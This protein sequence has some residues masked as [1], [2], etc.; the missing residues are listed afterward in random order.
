MKQEA[1][2]KT[3]LTSDYETVARVANLEQLPLAGILYQLLDSADS[4]L[5]DD[6]REIWVRS[7]WG[8]IA[9][10]EAWR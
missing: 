1:S 8:R 2:W 7:V 9:M 4:K 3:E 6:A 5:F 10:P